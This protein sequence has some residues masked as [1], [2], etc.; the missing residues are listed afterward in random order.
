MRTSVV[1]LRLVVRV[2]RLQPDAVLLPEEA[3]ERD[4]V[5]LHLGDDDVPVARRLLLAG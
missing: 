3:L 5:L 1:E 2:G 4:R